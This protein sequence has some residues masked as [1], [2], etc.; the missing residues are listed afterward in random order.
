VLVSL[1]RDLGADR[2][3]DPVLALVAELRAAWNRLGEVI[4]EG[5]DGERYDGANRVFDAAKAELLETPPTTLAGARAAGWSNTTSPTFQK[6]A[7]N[8]CGR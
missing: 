6:R 8:T 2:A 4:K 3:R 7:A 1:F 5:D